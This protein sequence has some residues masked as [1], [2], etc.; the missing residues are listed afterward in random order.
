M[1]LRG[2]ELTGFIKWS[3][4]GQNQIHTKLLDNNIL[5]LLRL[6]HSYFLILQCHPGCS[7]HCPTA[8]L[9]IPWDFLTPVQLGQFGPYHHPPNACVPCS[10]NCPPGELKCWCKFSWIPTTW[11]QIFYRLILVLV[12]QYLNDKGAL[13]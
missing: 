7:R 3:F 12:T 6:I 8:C 10:G 13:T 11:E 1:A 2:V 4:F 5:S 9:R